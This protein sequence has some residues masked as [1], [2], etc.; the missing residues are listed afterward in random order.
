MYFFLFYS[1]LTAGSLNGQD[2]LAIKEDAKVCLDCHGKQ[3]FILHNTLTGQDEK[4]L[5]NPYYIIDTVQYLGGVHRSFTCT[6]C[7]SMDYGSYPHNGELKLEPLST[8][9]DCHGGDET[10]AKFQFERIDEE[11]QKSVHFMKSGESFSCSKCHNQHYY[12]NT[13]RNSQQVSEIVAYNNTICLSCHN[14]LAKYQ[15]VSD[16]NNP[17][18]G[19]VHE[20]LPNQELHF[21]SVR[22]I[23]CHTRVTD[24]LLV[25]HHIMPKDSAVQ[26]CVQ[27]HSANS[28]LKA[29][30][31][32]YENLR[33][34][35][36]GD[37]TVN[38]VIQN[39]A[40][41]IG[42]NQIPALKIFSIVAFL[43]ALAGI[44]GHVFFRFLKK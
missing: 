30:L 34:R 14:N 24:T 31:Y 5:M 40:Y 36:S 32:K 15:L 11:F 44:L 20:W 35:S 27:C 6:D 21:K 23:E 9:L 12:K 22:C 18:L 16:Q 7:H 3:T 29:S 28:M 8:C 25:S 41:I 19:Q 4:R 33:A 26:N 37:G 2:Q 39:E 38:A 1:C 13:A 17:V 42:A 10:Y 43:L